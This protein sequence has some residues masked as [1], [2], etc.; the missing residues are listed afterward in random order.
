MEGRCWVTETAKR[1]FG[2]SIG[3][4]RYASERGQSAAPEFGLRLRSMTGIPHESHR[5]MLLIEQH[6]SDASAM[7]FCTVTFILAELDMRKRS[8]F[9]HGQPERDGTR[10]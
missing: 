6:T 1:K 10:W 4:C 3:S 8:V 9:D 5:G 2:Q 7:E